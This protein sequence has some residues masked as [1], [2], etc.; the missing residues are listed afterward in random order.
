M[1]DTEI[2]GPMNTNGEF[3][4]EVRGIVER[5]GML[6]KLQQHHKKEETKVVYEEERRKNLKK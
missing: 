4:E 2:S 6:H 5:A 3:D 1:E